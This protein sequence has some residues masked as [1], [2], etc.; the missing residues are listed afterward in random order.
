MEGALMNNNLPALVFAVCVAVGWVRV[1]VTE[2]ISQMGDQTRFLYSVSVYQSGHLMISSII[3][4]P[5]T[6]LSAFHIRGIHFS[7]A[8]LQAKD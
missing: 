6:W 3:F 7:S 2:I 4:P 8:L 1:S 5:T